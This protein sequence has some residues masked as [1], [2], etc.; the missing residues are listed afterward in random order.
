MTGI[1]YIRCKVKGHGEVFTDFDKKGMHFSIIE[2][3]AEGVRILS[4][5]EFEVNTNVRMKI[6]LPALLFQV[7]IRVVSRIVSKTKVDNSFEYDMAFIG[8][9]EK[10]MQEIDELMKSACPQY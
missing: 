10:D 1:N 9:P 5:Y 7:N 3:S 6:H 4:S 2:M 8:L